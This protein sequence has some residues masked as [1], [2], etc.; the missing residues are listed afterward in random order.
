MVLV[1][2]KLIDLMSLLEL[3]NMSVIKVMVDVVYG[4]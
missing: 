1:I 4:C 2:L 3:V